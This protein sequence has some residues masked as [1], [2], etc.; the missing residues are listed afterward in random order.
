M[1]LLYLRGFLP[2]TPRAV[3]FWPPLFRFS[4]T[5]QPCNS[6]CF[7]RFVQC[8]EHCNLP[9]HGKGTSS[10]PS[11][12]DTWFSGSHI[13]IYRPKTVRIRLLMTVHDRDKKGDICCLLPW[14]LHGM[15]DAR[16]TASTLPAGRFRRFF[17]AQFRLGTVRA[18][19]WPIR[20]RALCLSLN[21]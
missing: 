17:L 2:E 9:H 7:A 12:P 18:N 3:A 1:T 20:G 19:P 11:S 5:D 4:Q 8:L 6:G 10:R 16:T 15:P 13:L 14:S 21:R